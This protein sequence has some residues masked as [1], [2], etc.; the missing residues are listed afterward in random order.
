M[1]AL[2]RALQQNSWTIYVALFAALAAL[3]ALSPAEATLGNVVKIVYAHGAAER[4]STYAFLIAGAL[5]LVQFALKNLSMTRW[6]R[7]VMETAIVFWLAQLVI[8][9]PAQMLAWGGITLSEPRVAS[10]LWVLLLTALVY[11]VARWIGE[12]QWFA[13][14]AIANT[15]ILLIVLRGGINILHPVDPII[16]SDSL[17][18]KIF[19]AGIVIVTGA[20]ALQ[21]ARDLAERGKA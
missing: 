4:V 5:G 14:A 12:P 9:A 20:L 2:T 10:V 15:A 13:F 3:L 16:D 11:V 19:Y 8:S 7:A 18:I 17:A 21:L 1:S 6:T